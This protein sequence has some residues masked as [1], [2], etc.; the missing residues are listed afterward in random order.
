MKV[1]MGPADSME[2][3]LDRNYN[4]GHSFQ[5]LGGNDNLMECS[6]NS[7]V[8]KN[9]VDNWWWLELK[10]SLDRRKTLETFAVRRVE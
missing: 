9:M 3:T 10:Y 2:Y 7:D 8:D 5:H 4:W 1:W 6:N